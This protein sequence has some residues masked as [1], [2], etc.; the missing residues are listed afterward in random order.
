MDVAEGWYVEYKAQVSNSS[1]IAKSISALANTYGGWVFYGVEEKSKAD[2]TAGGF[3]GIISD[4]A[5]AALQRIRQAVAQHMNPAAHFDAKVVY[6]DGFQLASDR[7]VVCLRVPQSLAAPHIHASGKIYRRVADGSEPKAETDR[8]LLDQ[9][10]RR[11]DQLRDDYK[12]WVERDPEFSKGEGEA[13]FLR[14]LMVADPWLDENP[15]LE[16][17]VAQL[18]PIFGQSVGLVSA[19]PFDTVYSAT[20]G[21]VARQASNNDPHNLGLTWRFREMLVSDVYVPLNFYSMKNTWQLS[22]HLVGY[23]QAERFI[24]VLYKKGYNSP[25]IVDL[26]FLFSIIVGIVETQRRLLTLANWKKPYHIKAR[27]LNVW[28]TLPFVDEVTVI[29]SFEADGLPVCLDG[30]VTTPSGT[31]P[32]TFIMID[33][34]LDN[35]SPHA[36]IL[37]QALMILQ[38]IAKAWG[39]PIAI[40]KELEP[41]LF[42]RLQKASA[43]AMDVQARRNEKQSTG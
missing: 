5:D 9:L 15:W 21:Y 13:P 17:N 25:R 34:M 32:E 19:I 33:Q 3:P 31:D 10:F 43:R 1:G 7:I 35:D 26:N 18:K 39:L 41:P 23:D 12:K 27:L 38:P 28:R 22:E 20:V 2:S 16:T 37:L 36:A 6:G 8:H 4:D 30:I 11:S 42:E 14:L 24:N 40:E 29:D